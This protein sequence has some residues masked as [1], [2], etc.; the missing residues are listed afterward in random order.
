MAKKQPNREKPKEET[1]NLEGNIGNI[2]KGFS[3]EGKGDVDVLS[4]NA[5]DIENITTSGLANIGSYKE[6]S[7]RAS[8]NRQSVK[9]ITL[10]ETSN[11][12]LVKGDHI[13]KGEVYN[14]LNA[15]PSVQRVPKILALKKDITPNDAHDVILE[16]NNAIVQN[17][18]ANKRMDSFN[19]IAVPEEEFTRRAIIG[20]VE[21]KI[22]GSFGKKGI[23]GMNLNL[24]NQANLIK[25]YRKDIKEQELLLQN[26]DTE[27]MAKDEIKH[28]KTK[29][30]KEFKLP[31]EITIDH[32]F[33][34]EKEIRI[35][36][37]GKP[38]RLQNGRFDYTGRIVPKKVTLK[39][40]EYD[41]YAD[42]S[43]Q[44][45]RS[46]FG[47]D[48]GKV[49]IKG[50]LAD[51][52]GQTET[53]SNI[54]FSKE[55]NFDCG[56]GDT[57][58]G[59]NVLD[60]I[61]SFQPEQIDLR[62]SPYDKLNRSASGTTRI[63]TETRSKPKLTKELQQLFYDPDKNSELNKW[64]SDPTHP[65][66]VTRI[67]MFQDQLEEFE[68]SSDRI[69]DL[70]CENNKVP[71]RRKRSPNAWGMTPLQYTCT[72]DRLEDR[73]GRVEEETQRQTKLFE[74]EIHKKG[75]D[76]PSKTETEKII[77][78]RVSKA[79]D[80]DP[81]FKKIVGCNT[82]E[83]R[84]KIEQI[85]AENERIMEMNAENPEEKIPLESYKVPMRFPT[86]N[87]MGDTEYCK[88]YKKAKPNVL[89]ETHKKISDAEFKKIANEI[90]NLKLLDKTPSKE[91]TKRW[92]EAKKGRKEKLE[93]PTISFRKGKESKNSSVLILKEDLN[94]F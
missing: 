74:A 33:E 15:K 20:E 82:E 9:D 41:I 21:S 11:G 56:E 55:I 40:I 47:K 76:H 10:T 81:D 68:K 57:K 24:Y 65:E 13:T 52:K 84:E 93:N 63:G 90:E 91:L 42:P 62:K 78:D 85:E 88:S 69:P 23:K 26:P 22:F 27:Q 66:R 46:V 87:A 60:E 53:I 6:K 49:V 31:K 94:K 59:D 38:I 29:F 37:K 75:K 79:L 30:Q 43:S 12:V 92:E 77:T 67:E 44:A 2:G 45:G 5:H 28:I 86:K 71:I 73:L 1:K 35:D 32:P 25:R 34:K 8:A 64:L 61:Y 36:A 4:S 19:I 51:I 54:D 83:E 70:S 39:N 50:G 72:D 7:A 18:I 80:D 14:I 16:T 17:N 89:Y 48:D 58:C 3:G